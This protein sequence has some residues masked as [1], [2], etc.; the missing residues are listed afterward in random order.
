MADAN[1]WEVAE[2]IADVA[3]D[4]GDV[5]VVGGVLKAAAGLTKLVTKAHRKERRQKR[6]ARRAKAAQRKAKNKVVQHVQGK[7]FVTRAE[8]EAEAGP[9]AVPAK[10]PPVL[11]IAG[12]VGLLALLAF[13]AKK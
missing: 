9:L 4:L 5:P 8:R 13:N 10:R 12:G 7:A 1:G 2:D 11:L 6:K 3:E